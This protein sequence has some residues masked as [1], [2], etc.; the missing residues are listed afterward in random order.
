MKKKTSSDNSQEKTK[1][2]PSAGHSTSDSMKS[3]EKGRRDASSV[4]RRHARDFPSLV[5]HKL[6]KGDNVLNPL[7]DKR[8][9]IKRLE[10]EREEK[11]KDS[12]K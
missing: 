9:G 3:Y 12:H 11:E 10:K 8:I 7:V 4:G 6:D 2:K 5:S 1:H